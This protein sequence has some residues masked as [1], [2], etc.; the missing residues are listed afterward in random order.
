MSYITPPP[1]K[2]GIPLDLQVAVD[3]DD[4]SIFIKIAGFDDFDDANEYAEFLGSSLPLILFESDV[5]H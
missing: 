3:P 5:K 4:N 1:L 2:D